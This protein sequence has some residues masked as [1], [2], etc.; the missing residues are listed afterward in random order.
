MSTEAW[1]S[2][3]LAELAE[4]IRATHEVVRQ[5]LKM[6]VENAMATGDLLIEAKAQIDHGDWTPW[7]R[8]H[9]KMSERTARL[10]MRL[11]KNREVIEAHVDA[12]SLTLNAAARLLASP[13]EEEEKQD[14]FI[15][16]TR[17]ELEVLWAESKVH[18]V[19]LIRRLHIAKAHFGDKWLE[20]LQQ[21]FP[22][23]TDP[24]EK[25]FSDLMGEIMLEMAAGLIPKDES[26]DKG[27]G[28]VRTVPAGSS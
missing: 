6:G 23:P 9:C 2:N 15:D 25:E 14:D 12:A 28:R 4:C 17:D 16:K 8:E 22:E 13:K 5:A 20:F 1:K 3:S 10:Y 21:E 11:A 26:G 27:L 24:Q 18:L 19:E 7:L